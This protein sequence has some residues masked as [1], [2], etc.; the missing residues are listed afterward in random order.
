MYYPDSANCRLG[1]LFPQ[2]GYVQ[3]GIKIWRNVLARD[4][5]LVLCPVGEEQIVAD[6]SHHRRHVAPNA[7]DVADGQTEAHKACGVEDVDILQ[8]R[9]RIP[10]PGIRGH[11]RGRGACLAHRRAGLLVVRSDRARGRCAVQSRL[12]QAALSGQRSNQCLRSQNRTQKHRRS[13]A[14]RCD[15]PARALISMLPTGVGGSS[16]RRSP[17]QSRRVGA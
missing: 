13:P 11:C 4:P 10:S 7:G 16:G 2:C 15:R 14:R 5:C 3:R 6:A 17:A 1:W 9:C 12:V 8:V